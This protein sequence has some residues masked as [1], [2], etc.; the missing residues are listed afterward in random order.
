MIKLLPHQQK[1]LNDTMQLNRVAYFLDM[2]LGKTYVGAEKMYQLDNSLNLLI[3]QKSKIKDWDDHISKNYP[4]YQVFNLTSK[5]DFE[6]FIACARLTIYC[7]GIINY[8]LAWRRK[9]LLNLK[10]FTLMLDES[11]LIQNEQAKQTKFILNLKPENVILL[12]GTPV[13]GKYERLWSQC[14]LLGWNISHHAYDSTYVNYVLADFGVG[15]PVRIVDKHD[16][17]KNVEHLKFKLRVH[18]AIFMKTEEVLT[19]P[20]QIFTTL[21]VPAPKEYCKFLKAGIT[22]IDNVELIGSTALTKR[23]YARQICSQYNN[24]KL[25]ALKDLINSS[26]DRFIVF[27]NFNDELDKLK[28]VAKDRPL[29]IVNGQAKDLSAYENE[30]NSVTLVQY[31]A[32]ALGL[33]LQK[34][35]KMIFFSLP[36][37]SDLFE[38]AKKRIHRIGTTNTCFY[39]ILSAENTID[40]AIYKALEQKKDFT[41]ELFK[42]YLK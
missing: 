8:E 18:G 1:V 25:D 5:K 36:E 35:N 32:G 24:R 41:D 42:E 20:E 27:Y 26:N 12:S 39:W 10:E 2:G 16:P 7:V 31:Q 9:E 4:D 38:Q 17:Y 13:S 3:C 6:Q 29:S 21:T 22:T 37:R 14:R 40:D 19:L 33:N 23:L 30:E 34:C 11:S 28:A 15:Y